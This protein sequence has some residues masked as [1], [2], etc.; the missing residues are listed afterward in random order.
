MYNKANVI[1]MLTRNNLHGMQVKNFLI[2]YGSSHGYV[3]PM[4]M[5]VVNLRILA[6]I[7]W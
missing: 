5:V 2:M 4:I 3:L 1:K 6:I 7:D